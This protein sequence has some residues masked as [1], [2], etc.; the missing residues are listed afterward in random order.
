MRRLA[1]LLILIAAAALTF[2]LALGP[3]AEW[4]GPVRLARFALVLGCMGTIAGSVRLIHPDRPK[5]EP[6]ETDG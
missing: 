5:G 3:S 6:A 4:E 1:G 2:W